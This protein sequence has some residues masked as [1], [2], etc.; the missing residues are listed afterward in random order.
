MPPMMLSMAAAAARRGSRG[1]A[2][3]AASGRV[4]G[5]DSLCA[6]DPVSALARA[7]QE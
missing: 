5:D 7:A 2:G 1:D 6:R 4:A 3:T